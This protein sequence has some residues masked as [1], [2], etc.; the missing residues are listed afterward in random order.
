MPTTNRSTSSLRFLCCLLSN[1][2]SGSI[3]QQQRKNPTGD[4][5]VGDRFGDVAGDPIDSVNWFV[6]G[7]LTIGPDCGPANVHQT[8]NA[9][10]SPC[11]TESPAC[12]R[13]GVFANHF[14]DRL[15]EGAPADREIGGDCSERQKPLVKLSSVMRHGSDPFGVTRR[16]AN[17]V[18]NRSDHEDQSSEPL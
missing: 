15:Q 4:Q 12:Y 18:K 1:S 14:I 10:R 3:G 17:Y 13:L 7:D 6:A 9:K 8:G 16:D 2:L 11:G 5:R